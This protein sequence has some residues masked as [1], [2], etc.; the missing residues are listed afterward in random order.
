MVGE[1]DD[2]ADKGA[3]FRDETV[4]AIDSALDWE[5][6]SAGQVIYRQGEPADSFYI[7]RYFSLLGI[8]SPS[9]Y[10]STSHSSTDLTPLSF[11][12]LARRSSTAD[13]DQSPK[14]PEEESI[15]TANT[16]K[17]NPSAN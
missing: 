3:F 9:L 5:H 10:L 13:S 12:S 8:P 7:V 6:V 17:A 15:F 4:L 16:A 11:F 14:S 1:E 2:E